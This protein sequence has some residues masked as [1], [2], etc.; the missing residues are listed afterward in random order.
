MM[1]SEVSMRIAALSLVAGLVAS[2]QAPK[3]DCVN[4]GKPDPAKT[5]SYEH[6]DSSGTVSHYTNRW[7]EF[8]D[9]RSRLRTTR[10]SRT[11]R[12]CRAARPAKC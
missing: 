3:F 11:P 10:G 2:A 9:T 5:F 1:P 4:I 6:K 8:T 7:L 12:R